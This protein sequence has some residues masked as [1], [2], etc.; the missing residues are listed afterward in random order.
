MPHPDLA[1][2]QTYVDHAYRCLAAMRERAAYLASLEESAAQGV[3]SAIAQAHLQYR[4]RT[5]DDDVP[6]LSFGR[7]DDEGDAT[8][9]IGR[10]HVEDA[11]G[12]PV[13]VDWRAEVATPFYRATAV[14]PQGLARRR[15]FMMTGK[16]LDDLWDEVFDDPD[17]VDAAHHGGIPDPLLA[18]LERERTG[19]MRDIVATIAAEQDVVIRAPLG[20]CLVVQGGPGTGK[21]AVGLHRAAFLLYEHRRRLD[22]E[23]VL[24]IGPNPLFLRYIAQ[25]LPSLGETAARQT[26]LD[27]LLAGTAY[28]AR[29]C[30]DDRAAAIKGDARMAAVVSRAVAGTVTVP[31][32]GLEAGTRWGRVR[33]PHE[34]VAAA[35]EE[36]AGRGVPHNVGRAAVRTQLVRMVRNDLVRRRGEEAV[37]VEEVEA[38]L[39]ANRE[40]GRALDRLWPALSAP[41]VVRRLVTSRTALAR[42]GEGILSAGEQA[43][44]L[45]PATR[46]VA[47]EPWTV[48]DLALLD[49]AEAAIS[50]PPRSYGHIVVDEAQDLSAMGLRALARRAPQ[51]SMTVLGDL[52]QAT[53]PGAQ[54]SWDAAIAHLGSPAVAQRA[55]LDVGYRV[56]AAIMDMANGLLATAAPDVTPCR[57][58]RAAGRPPGFVAV[59]GD[60]AGDS[61]DALAGAVGEAVSRLVDTYTTVGVV[62]P[63]DLRPAVRRAVAAHDGAVTLLDPPEAKGL[64]FDAVV[65]VEPEGIAG[66]TARGLRLLYVA[67][68]RAVQELV[69]VHAAP[70]P[71]DLA[72][73]AAASG[74]GPG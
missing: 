9:Y 74:D 29:G 68:T 44:V 15:R 63:A 33:L 35:V 40:W 70:L 13:V 28:R 25:V 22:A 32:A 31:A 5:L 20:T 8:W 11:G 42:S 43:A 14:D 55:D 38:D 62:V 65:V 50:G 26:T 24:V 18:E 17:S 67:L 45:R 60:S 34:A 3:D 73:S 39:R 59:P 1:A 49:E 57:S 56:P 41:A 69:V 19:E 21:T 16:Q 4:V 27:R 66:A 30:D 46:K 48:A 12:D 7:L 53:A 36:V 37:P 51:G 58:V 23:G 10:R 64:E 52:A 6:G 72:A 47:D 61:A 2:E 71:A 54:E